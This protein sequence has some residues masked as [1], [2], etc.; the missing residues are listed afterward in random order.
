MSAHQQN[1]VRVDF[2]P[3][4]GHCESGLPHMNCWNDE[5]A[6]VKYAMSRLQI[7]VVLLLGKQLKPENCS[8]MKAS[9]CR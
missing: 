8:H 3:S 4:T 1:T 5:E 7:G 2:C 6:P 9:S